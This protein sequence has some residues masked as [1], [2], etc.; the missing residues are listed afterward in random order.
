MMMTEPTEFEM[1]LAIYSDVHKDAY[2]FRPDN[3]AEVRN[4]SLA[5]LE[6][7]IAE[8]SEIVSDQISLEKAQDEQGAAALI[9]VHNKLMIDQNI[10][11]AA[12]WR[13]LLQADQPD[14]TE[15]MGH[16][17]D[18]GHFLWNAGV[19]CGDIAENME[20][21]ILAMLAANSV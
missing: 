21:E 2:G 13:W 5:Q 4:W 3:W 14:V 19:G 7:E 6:Q 16:I 10:G 18:I 15:D 17:Y 9:E 20:I 8:L 11:S 12:A 1:T